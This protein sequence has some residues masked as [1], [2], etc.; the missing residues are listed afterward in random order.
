MSCRTIGQSL[1]SVCW[2]EEWG[3]KFPFCPLHPSDFPVLRPSE[4][5]VG[6]VNLGCR[7]D[8]G[9]GAVAHVDIWICR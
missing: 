3:C 5:P 4:F 8:D 7:T 2:L 1:R 9:Y 6:F